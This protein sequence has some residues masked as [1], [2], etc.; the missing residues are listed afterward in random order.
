MIRVV[1]IGAGNVAFHLSR[2]MV[3]STGIR[4]VQIY[5]RSEKNASSLPVS[6]P[7]TDELGALVEADIYVIAV[8]D[9]AISSLAPAL[10]HLPGLVVH[11]SGTV[12][13][14]VL[15]GIARRG[16]LYPVQTFSKD[17]NLDW[18]SIPMALLDAGDLL[19]HVHTS[20]NDRGTPGTGTVNWL[21]TRCWNQNWAQSTI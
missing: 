20:E 1:I 10:K 4:L 7:R 5:S 3:D 2:A 13:M 19:Y 16:V 11:T 18:K 15:S 17:R 9:D 14:D 6:V 8:R 12:S 21:G